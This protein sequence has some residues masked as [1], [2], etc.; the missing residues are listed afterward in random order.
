M[1]ALDASVEFDM[2]ITIAFSLFSMALILSA[3]AMLI[4]GLK[5]R[6]VKTVQD[7]ILKIIY[8]N[9]RLK[10]YKNSSRKR[11]KKI[12][13]KEQRI[14]SRKSIDLVRNTVCWTDESFRKNL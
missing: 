4:V 13:K 3:I 7:N 12:F 8:R 10:L 14:Q 9:S 6:Q 11:P 1:I 2:Y 5:A